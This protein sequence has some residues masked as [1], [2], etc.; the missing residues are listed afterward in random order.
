MATYDFTN[1]WDTGTYVK[2]GY[3]YTFS[4][5]PGG[6][7]FSAIALAETTFATNAYDEGG[8][9]AP[10]DGGNHGSDMQASFGSDYGSGGVDL[11]NYVDFDYSDDG[12]SEWS[13]MNDILGDTNTVGSFATAIDAEGE[14]FISV[15][16]NFN[17][18]STFLSSNEGYTLEEDKLFDLWHLDGLVSSHFYVTAQ[19]V[20]VDTTLTDANLS[21]WGEVDGYMNEGS[22][23]MLSWW[24]LH[25]DAI[26]IDSFNMSG[27]HS[28]GDFTYTLNIVTDWNNCTYDDYKSFDWGYLDYTNMSA[29]EFSD[30][31]WGYIEYEEFT[32]S[33]YTDIDW[34][35]AQFNEFGNDDYKKLHWGKVQYKEFDNGVYK[36]ASWKK[37]QMKEFGNDDY[38][39]INWGQVQYKEVLKSNANLNKVNWGKVQTNEWDKGDLKILTKSSTAKKLDKLDNAELDINVLKKGKSFKGDS[40][41]DVITT[42]GG[43]LKKKVKVKGGAG[44]DTFV[45]KKGKGSLEIQD[46]KNKQDEIN[47][48]YCGSSSKIKL[49]Q[50]G[51]DTLIYSG[52]DLLATVKK[53]KKST[54]KKSAF[55]LV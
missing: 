12:S 3:T 51:K 23:D 2:D 36:Q 30:M 45:L 50:K 42:S 39:K 1:S 11:L 19:I 29:T 17:G 41:D 44:N 8:Y 13:A 32:T 34:G 5:T 4:T 31:N 46:F 6:D 37:V 20:G 9:L 14:G 7:Y 40:D 22:P 49:K 35:Y 43:L 21:V 55:G 27:D 53:T 33:S 25:D 52:K 26:A 48:A 10:G 38:K 16:S 15:K 47:F 28:L 24:Y 18:Y 54:L